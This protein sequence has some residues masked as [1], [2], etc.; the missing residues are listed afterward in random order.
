LN[1]RT[2]PLV[3][4]A[5][6]INIIA[7]ACY[8]LPILGHMC[9]QVGKEKLVC[10]NYSMEFG[11]FLLIIAIIGTLLLSFEGIAKKLFGNDGFNTETLT[12]NKG[13]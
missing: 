3:N 1:F 13:E 11:Y 10:L 12:S 6:A 7:A 4:I 2:N 5:S 9:K 8:W